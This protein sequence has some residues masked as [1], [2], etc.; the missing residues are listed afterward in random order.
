M[1]FLAEVRARLGLDTTA[2]SRGLT[3]A[4]AD[5]GTAS[6]DIGKKL[7][8]AFGAGDVFR[9]L[10]AGLGIAS[11][12]GVV[13]QI[14]RLW[15]GMTKEVEQGYEKAI[16]AQER[17]AE[18]NI[19]RMRQMASLETQYQL[20]LIERA[21]LEKQMQQGPKEA[22]ASMY[23]NA[24]R[25][26]Q[27]ATAGVP[28]FGQIGAMAG[29][30]ADMLAQGRRGEA[31]ARKLEDDAKAGMRLLEIE[32]ETNAVLNEQGKAREKLAA[33]T[34]ELQRLQEE[35]RQR[36][37]TDEQRLSD[38]IE[39]R[40]NLEAS[41]ALSGDEDLFYAREIEK[42]TGRIADLEERI[43]AARVRAVEQRYEEAQQA[44]EEQRR[45]D[46]EYLRRAKE[47]LSVGQQVADAEERV[48]KAKQDRNKAERA[49]EQQRRDRS[50][51]T[52]EEVAGGQYQATQTQRARAREVLRLEE[53]AKRQRATGFEAEAA[54][55]TERALSLRQRIGSLISGEADP[56]GQLREALRESQKTQDEA[57][58]KLKEI[59]GHLKPS[60]IQ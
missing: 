38:L 59:E 5:V 34:L 31:A 57:L 28:I 58:G 51:L 25:S 41:R 56:M 17:L 6:A 55:S 60:E 16:Q 44:I 21:R 49:L 33:A 26:V 39:K 1:A 18:A 14:A 23:E 52:L 32:T 11:V 48:A 2:F 46:E 50:G 43:E 24:L 40:A 30:S 29:A 45:S 42:T 7:N 47:I 3:K 22:P 35:N 13:D 12:Q 37:L 4:Q 19:K 54:K 10:L 36:L 8:R 15:T 9:G 53:Q 20:L 27:E